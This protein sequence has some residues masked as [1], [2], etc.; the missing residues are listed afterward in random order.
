MRREKSD[1]REGEAAQRYA[2]RYAVYN[3]CL[4]RSTRPSR[5]LDRAPLSRDPVS[6]RPVT[7][8]SYSFW[9]RRR[10]PDVRDSREAGSRTGRGV[11]CRPVPPPH[12]MGPTTFAVEYAGH[13]WATARADE[14]PGPK[15]NTLFDGYA[16]SWLPVVPPISGSHCRPI[17][18][19]LSTADRR[20]FPAQIAVR[21]L[22]R[23]RKTHLVPIRR[24]THERQP[25]KPSERF[26]NAVE[27]LRRLP[28][29][30]AS[31][32]T[33]SHRKPETGVIV[34]RTSRRPVAT[35]PSPP[36]G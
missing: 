30:G 28:A 23:G 20:P 29:T 33:R 35:C 26:N 11:D 14:R 27:G 2:K 13:A 25:R 12:L 9:L 8:T 21:T 5:A 4:K 24:N 17:R 19:G 16:H 36:S 1:G 22:S 31:P 10:F 32:S 7:P 15:L 3:Y 34:L 18:L 6:L